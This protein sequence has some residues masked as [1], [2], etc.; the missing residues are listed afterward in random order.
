MNELEKCKN[1]I[2]YFI[3]NYCTIDGEYIKLKDYQIKMLKNFD[4]CDI[5]KKQHEVINKLYN[6][7]NKQYEKSKVL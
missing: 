1:D 2:Q 6:K 5:L 3:E 7:I 4:N